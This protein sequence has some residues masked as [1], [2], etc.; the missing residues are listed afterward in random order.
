MSN[1]P[2]EFFDCKALNCFCNEDGKC[3]ALAEKAGSPCPFY[4]TKAKQLLEQAALQVKDWDNYRA[5]SETEAP[6]LQDILTWINRAEQFMPTRDDRTKHLI[7]RFRLKMQGSDKAYQKLVNWFNDH[8]DQT[9][10]CMDAE[11][12]ALSILLDG[13]NAE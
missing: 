5:Q 2:L 11:E 8:P 9:G 1:K 6:T 4:K 7:R 3:R 13:G 10:Y 12:T